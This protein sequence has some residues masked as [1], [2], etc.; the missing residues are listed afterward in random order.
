MLSSFKKK[1]LICPISFGRVAAAI[2]LDLA[3]FMVT[4]MVHT[5]VYSTKP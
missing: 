3:C 1:L 5:F 2:S 4:S